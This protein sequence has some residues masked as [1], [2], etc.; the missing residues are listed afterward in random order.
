MEYVIEYSKVA[1][2]WMVG[3]KEVGMWGNYTKFNGKYFD[4]REQA[5]DWCK[6]KKSSVS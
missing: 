3:T 2:K 6:S 4:S 5:D 1:R